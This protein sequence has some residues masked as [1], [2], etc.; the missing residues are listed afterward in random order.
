VS[1]PYQPTGEKLSKSKDF[2]VISK[3]PKRVRQECQQCRGSAAQVPDL[4]GPFLT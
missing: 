4:F 1:V 3:R 2:V